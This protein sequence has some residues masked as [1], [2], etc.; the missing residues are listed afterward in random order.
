MDLNRSLILI[1][2]FLLHIVNALSFESVKQ[3]EV[4]GNKQVPIDTILYYLDFKVGDNITEDNVGKS[5][6]NLY[7]QGFFSNIS[8]KQR[9]LSTIVVNVEERPIIL[10]IN[11][12]GNNIIKA[13][14]IEKMLESKVGNLYSQFTMDRDIKKIEDVYKKLGYFLV[15]VNVNSKQEIENRVTITISINEAKKILLN[16]ISFYG[17]KDLSQQDL[18]GVISSNR[19]YWYNSLFHPLYNH[20]R[21]TIDKLLLKKHYKN[22]GYAD[23]QVLSSTTE[24]IPNRESSLLTYVINEGSKFYFAKSSI[25]CQIKGIK[26]FTLKKSISYREGDVFNESLINKSIS[27]ISAFLEKQGYIFINIDYILYKDK[28]N[29]TIDIQYIITETSKYFVNNINITGNYRTR[30]RVIRRELKI[31]EGDPFN[32]PNIQISKQ[33]ISN[34][35]Y[36]NIVEL[37]HHLI[38][39]SNKIDL[40]I[41]LK[42]K[43]TGSMRFAIG[44]NTSAGLIGS[45]TLSEY[46]FLGKGQVIEFDFNKATKSSDISFSITEPRFIDRNLAVGFDIFRVSED[47]SDQGYSNVYSDGLA[48]RIG[49]DMNEYLYHSLHYSIKSRQYHKA[50]SELLFLQAQLKKT[51]LSLIGQSIT[52][53]KLNSTIKP[54]QGYLI[55]FIQNFAVVG[56]DARYL[57]NQIHLSYFQ[58]LYDK[59]V[60][61]NFT[62]RAGNIRGMSNTGVN[63][64]DS[65]FIGE[66]YVRGFDVS[67]IGPRVKEGKNQYS[68]GGKTFFVWSAEAKFS[69]GLPEDFGINGAIFT[70]F[71]T[72]FNTDA[73]KLKYQCAADNHSQLNSEHFCEGQKLK[74]E[75]INDSKSIRASYGIALVWDSPLGLIRIDY[76]IPYIKESFDKES[77]VR[78][79]IGRNF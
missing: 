15:L 24:I 27:K 64:S 67:G 61:F 58:S 33:K 68:I 34:L 66:E 12:K 55:K 70:D 62:G 29:K 17:N 35:G 59:K 32:F 9:Q 57:Q 11:I 10:N 6:K 28:E 41:K 16:K 37:D 47:K 73:A 51:R 21:V 3:I 39:S 5:L 69:L 7:A 77:R 74:P 23:F 75:M 13:E 42:E 48:F 30:D 56:G 18:L 53:D 72:L 38:S 26:T 31:Y 44:Y 2:T 20:E 22:Y 54:T 46:N 4:L 79:S 1:L 40:E 19:P 78:F 8:I 45:T 71:G 65:F 63:S 36:F 76:G 14:K 43:P 50:R 60:M 49:Y 25:D 52:Y